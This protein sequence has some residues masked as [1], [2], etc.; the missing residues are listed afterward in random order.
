MFFV[1]Y[2]KLNGIGYSWWNGEFIKCNI[3]KC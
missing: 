1:K 3:D 2:E